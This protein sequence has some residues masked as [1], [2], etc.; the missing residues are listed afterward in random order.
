MAGG[1]LPFVRNVASL[2]CLV[3]I[4]PGWVGSVVLMA[5][6][7]LLSTHVT[8]DIIYFLKV[9]TEPFPASFTSVN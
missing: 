8:T 5:A 1:T 6:F 9:Q 7:G 2:A 4:K 3:V